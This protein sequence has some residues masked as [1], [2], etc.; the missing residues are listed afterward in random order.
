M[1]QDYSLS[2]LVFFFL[3]AGGIWF[4][5]SRPAV[6]IVEQKQSKLVFYIRP[7]FV[8]GVTFF[9]GGLGFLFLVSFLLILFFKIQ[10]NDQTLGYTYFE[11]GAFLAMVSFL[12][13]AAVPTII[14]TLNQESNNLSLERH[15]YMG[16]KK[17]SF[18]VSLDN[19]SEVLLESSDG[20]EGMTYRVTFKLT[21]NERLPLTYTYSSGYEEKQQLAICIRKFLNWQSPKPN[22]E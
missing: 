1:E 3:F 8:W 5:I 10:Q 20:S 17:E 13:I 4:C 18:Q 6:K 12:L 22:I 16:A 2:G 11:I 19:I 9:L 14:C 21:S 7:I 15:S